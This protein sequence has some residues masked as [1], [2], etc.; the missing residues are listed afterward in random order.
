MCCH[1]EKIMHV[2]VVWMKREVQLLLLTEVFCPLPLT[3]A[4]EHRL[5]GLSFPFSISIIHYIIC[6]LRK[7]STLSK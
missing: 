5:H 2:N 3:K 6:I 4:T 7:N 1:N